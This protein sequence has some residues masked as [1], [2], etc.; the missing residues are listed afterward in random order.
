MYFDQSTIAEKLPGETYESLLNHGKAQH[1]PLQAYEV[2]EYGP[3]T[4]SGRNS[5]LLVAGLLLA[6]AF[7]A[8]VIL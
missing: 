6:L 4:L 2:A 8:K 1:L 5:K 3:R 7:I